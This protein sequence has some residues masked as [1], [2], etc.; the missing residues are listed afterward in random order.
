MNGP[1]SKEDVM[2]DMM[3]TEQCPGIDMLR[4]G[5]LVHERY[6]DLLRYLLGRPTKYRWMLP[7]W[8]KGAAK[9]IEK[10]EHFST[11]RTYQLFHD[12]G[13]PY[14]RKVGE[15]GKVRYPDH[16]NISHNVARRIHLP[17]TV[18]QLIQLDMVC[19][20]PTEEFEKHLD[21]PLLPSLLLTAVAE[22]YANSVLFGGCDDERF[23]IKHK[24]ILSRVK[25]LI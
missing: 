21:N 17:D 11:M 18:C 14:A 7:E 1:W 10:Q 13:K 19:H 6:R 15:D 16:A 4:H 5:M 12:C 20:G 9:L 22:I 23:K 8:F 2:M 24:K 25:R 3:N